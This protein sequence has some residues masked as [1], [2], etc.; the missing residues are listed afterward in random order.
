MAK[1]PLKPAP[2]PEEIAPSEDAAEVVEVNPEPAQAQQADISPIAD[3]SVRVRLDNGAPVGL[4]IDRQGGLRGDT[5]TRIIT[6]EPPDERLHYTEP[7]LQTLAMTLALLCER[8][9]MAV[10]QDP[11]SPLRGLHRFPAICRYAEDIRKFS[12]AYQDRKKG[13]SYR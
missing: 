2:Q 12:V 4:Y 11:L 7:Q 13:S 1:R 10:E 8:P 6:L 3:G 9:A 5:A